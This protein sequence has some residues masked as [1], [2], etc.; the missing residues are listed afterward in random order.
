MRPYLEIPDTKTVEKTYAAMNAA[1][2][3]V[4]WKFG[5]YLTFGLYS[6]NTY[7]CEV[8]EARETVKKLVLSIPG[9]ISMHAFNYDEERNAM[10]T[11]TT[12]EASA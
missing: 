3:D 11:W 6:V 1:Q 4:Y 5:I 10:R 12:R 8:V 7:G 2:R 9:T